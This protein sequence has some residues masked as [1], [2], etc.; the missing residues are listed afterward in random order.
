[1]QNG[2]K[3]TIL[4][5]GNLTGRYKDGVFQKNINSNAFYQRLRALFMLK[6][7][8]D[9]YKELPLEFTPVDSCANAAFTIIASE[10]TAGRVYHLKN[11]NTV[12]MFDLINYFDLPK[13]GFQF[14]DELSFL[15]RLQE[16]AKEGNDYAAAFMQDM[17]ESGRI[18]FLNDIHVSSDLTASFLKQKGFTWPKADKCFIKK[19]LRYMKNTNYIKETKSV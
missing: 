13:K 11:H 7:L 12:Q 10:N 6:C 16:C 8:Q 18:T 1:M 3:A 5:V 9:V 15:N 14:V 4:R 2:L 17:D 19:V